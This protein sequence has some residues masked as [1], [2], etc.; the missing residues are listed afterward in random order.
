MRRGK[1]SLQNPGRGLD[2]KTRAEHAADAERLASLAR[3]TFNSQ[4]P[5][6]I[7]PRLE[8][9]PTLY[10][11]VIGDDV[12]ITLA[13]SFIE[14]GFGTLDMWNRSGSCSQFIVNIINDWL[15]KIGATELSDYA[16]LNLVFT[17]EVES[18]KVVEGTI[19][20]F[21]E[22]SMSGYITIGK[23]VDAIER[24]CPGLGRDFYTVLMSSVYRWMRVYD[25]QDAEMLVE[26]WRE[27]YEGDAEAANQSLDE[28]FKSQE[29]HIPNVEECIPTYLAKLDFRKVNAA[30]SRLRQHV[31]GEFGEWIRTVLEMSVLRPKLKCN[32]RL[33]FEW[34]DGPVP[35]WLVVYREHDAIEQCWDEESQTWNETS[36][37]PTWMTVFDPADVTSLRRVLEEV[38][39]YV[40]IAKCLVALGE[41]FKTFSKE[42]EHER[43]RNRGKR[44]QLRAA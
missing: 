28:Y 7:L 16:G 15:R 2:G 20:A 42:R 4:N 31:G 10:S 12:S 22:T 9:Q 36:H 5:G 13:R 18:E 3:L 11:R 8:A 33:D 24:F 44:S 37:Q 6:L 35:S 39:K 29:I 1:T 26:M 14:A 19:L 27:N 34:D 30:A 21:I 38:E 32:E 23:A 41:S 43:L 25:H 17:T 40:R